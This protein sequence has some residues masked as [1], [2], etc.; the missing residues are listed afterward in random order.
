[1]LHSWLV[2]IL[3][4]EASTNL[5]IM[6][7]Q[8]KSMNIQHLSN[9]SEQSGRDYTFSEHDNKYSLKD[10]VDIFSQGVGRRKHFSYSTQYKSSIFW[11]AGADSRSEASHESTYKTDFVRPQSVQVPTSYRRFPHNHQNKAAEKSRTVQTCQWFVH[12][13]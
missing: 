4:L 13:I 11:A 1:M 8:V 6:L 7:S 10:D 9:K 3:Y 12:G 2:E 5:G